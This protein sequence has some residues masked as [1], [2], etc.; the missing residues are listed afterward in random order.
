LTVT[1]NVLA[2][3]LFDNRGCKSPLCHGNILRELAVKILDSV[4]ALPLPRELK[5]SIVEIMN[6]L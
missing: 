5:S 1:A 6:D 2:T 3:T 4:E